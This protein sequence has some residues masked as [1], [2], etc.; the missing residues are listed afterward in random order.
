MNSKLLSGP[1]ETLVDS[2][3]SLDP[4]QKELIYSIYS[5]INSTNDPPATGPK[6]PK[7]QEFG[8]TLPDDYRQQVFFIHSLI[9]TLIS[10]VTMSSCTQ[11]SLH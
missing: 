1:L 5:L 7:E 6:D 4:E 9:L 3:L 2:V 8:T 11:G 10:P